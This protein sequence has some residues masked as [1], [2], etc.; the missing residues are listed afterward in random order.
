M[1]F[2]KKAGCLQKGILP[3]VSTDFGGRDEGFAE[4]TED[5]NYRS[6]SMG[7]CQGPQRG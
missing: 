2:L 6:M 4:N 3:L 1:S 7:H 5:I